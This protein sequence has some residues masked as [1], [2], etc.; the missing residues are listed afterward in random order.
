MSNYNR[1]PRPIAVMGGREAYMH[2]CRHCGLDANSN[3]VFYHVDSFE[4]AGSQLFSRLLEIT[5]AEDTRDYRLVKSIALDN[6]RND[7]VANV[8]QHELG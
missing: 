8:S 5:G 4:R 3:D 7:S 6:V 1:L 2:L